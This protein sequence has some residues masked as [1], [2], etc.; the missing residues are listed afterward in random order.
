MCII[1][2]II[3][4]F[5]LSVLAFLL[6]FKQAFLPLSY[7]GVDN[8]NDLKI[9]EH[10]HNN[11]LRNPYDQ[12]LLIRYTGNKM[13]YI[14]H[15]DNFGRA[16]TVLDTFKKIVLWSGY[17][18]PPGDY[19]FSINDGVNAD[20]GWP[21]LAFAA[22]RQLVTQGKAILIPDY[23][24]LTNMYLGAFKSIDKT[25]TLYPWHKKINKIFWRGSLTGSTHM[26]NDLLGSDRLRMLNSVK[27]TNFTDVSLTDYSTQHNAEFLQKVKK[28]YPLSKAIAP[29]H[30]I[31]YKYLLDVDGNSCSYTRMAWILYSN[32]ALFKHQ[33]D[34]MQWYYD[35]L[36]PYVH[37]VPIK[38][39]FSNLQEQYQWAEEHPQEMQMIATQGHELA[40]RVFNSKAILAAMAQALIKYQAIAAN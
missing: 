26:N 17:K 16:Q 28:L 38:N 19:L 23:E 24:A 3:R 40:L 14:Y 27:N 20:F 39:D 5:L 30:S 12:L 29:G 35:Q 6:V 11:L 8:L 18:I 10:L 34:R 33:S 37:Y 4:V 36:Q 21:V 2:K 15:S 22:P 9:P 1:H 31:A 32:S 25:L 7:Q 13:Q